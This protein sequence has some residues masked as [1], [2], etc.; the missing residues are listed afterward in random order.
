MALTFSNDESVARDAVMRSELKALTEEQVA[1]DLYR[2]YFDGEQPLVYSTELFE[3]VFGDAFV[4]FKDNWMKVI[5]NAAKNRLKLINFH[6]EDDEDGSRAKEIWRILRLNEWSVQQKDLHE[7]IMVE[8]RA[9]VIVWPDPTMGATVDW[10]PGQICRV[11]YDPD[12]RTKALWAVKRW[13]T[14]TGEIFVTFYTPD[15]VFKYVDKKAS[16]A[17]K[18]PSSSSALSEVPGVGWFGNLQRREVAGEQWPLVNPFGVVPV[19]EFNNTSYVSELVDAIPQQDALNKMLL[20][21]IIT[22]EYQAFRQRAIETM[23]ASPEGGWK[24]GPGEIWAFKPSFDADGKHIPTQFHE[25]ETSD[26]SMFMEPIEMWLGHMAHTSSTPGR[27]FIEGDSGGRGDAPSGEALLVDDKP[28][29]DKVEE[30]QERLG[31]RYMEVA[32]L[33]GIATKMV[34]AETILG[35]AIWQDPRHDYRLSKL[36]EGAAMVDMG[37]P[38]EFAVKKIGFTPDEEVEILALIEVQK[39]ELEAK[40]EAEREAANSQPV[41]NNSTPSTSNDK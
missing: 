1:M 11:F 37:I 39:A 22:G 4:G 30:K 36:Q 29:N 34:G 8:G 20:D 38:I 17:D 9:F 13:T 23:S 14:E 21:M 33:I 3:S 16:S 15:A 32:R 24:A 19:V 7:G 35:D 28:L 31:P 27:Y 12:R 2:S 25:F 40:E 10:Q 41:I 5:V 6:F 18:T 26:P